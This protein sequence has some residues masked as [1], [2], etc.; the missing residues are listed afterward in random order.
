MSSLEELHSRDDRV[1]MTS[2]Q[3]FD[4]YNYLNSKKRILCTK[5]M[6]Q[7]MSFSIFQRKH[8]CLTKPL[9]DQIAML[10]SSGLISFWNSNFRKNDAHRE[11]YE[12][13]DGPKRLNISQFN[14]LMIICVT[15]YIIGILIFVL[16]L[17]SVRHKTI[18]TIIDFISFDGFK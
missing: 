7:M 10:T 11:E 16:E 2:T 3:M 5:E 15:L 18:K 6:I 13:R 12:N 9:N 4:Y 14:G 17:M 1:Y 8:S